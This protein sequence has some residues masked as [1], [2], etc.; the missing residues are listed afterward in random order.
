MIDTVGADED[1]EP[2]RPTWLLEEGGP[3]MTATP[4]RWAVVVDNVNPRIVMT[5]QQV[6]GDGHWSLLTLDEERSIPNVTVWLGSDGEPE[7]I[8]AEGGDH[9]RALEDQIGQTVYLSERLVAGSP[10]LDC[11]P[12]ARWTWWHEQLLVSRD[13]PP[14]GVSSG[15]GPFTEA[16]ALAQENQERRA[17]RIR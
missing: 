11:L 10:T 9:M 2:G 1:T 6:P 15:P 4:R 14:T 13:A 5:A 8:E 12:A 16:L 7:L 17:R 3:S